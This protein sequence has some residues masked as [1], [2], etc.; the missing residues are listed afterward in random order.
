MRKNNKRADILQAALSVVEQ[1]G[2]GHLTIDAVAAQSGF[3]KGGVLYHF[4]TKKALISGM[5]EYLIESSRQRI[6]AHT[7]KF[8]S[9][10]PLKALLQVENRM[11]DTERRASLAIV[12]AAAE[13]P[14]LLSPARDYIKDLVGQITSQ[15]DDPTAAI[16][17]YLANEGLR[18]LDIFEL[19]PMN[20]EQNKQVVAYLSQKAEEL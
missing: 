2:A 16:V 6:D 10:Q 19:N 1:H 13:D 11:T 17:H 4:A 20:T 7:E 15:S 14:E 5:L 9:D 8:G 18:F 12:A 3:S